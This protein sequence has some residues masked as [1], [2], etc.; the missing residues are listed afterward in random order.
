LAG[1]GWTW[2]VLDETGLAE[3]KTAATDKNAASKTAETIF[4]ILI[5]LNRM[6]C[7]NNLK[8]R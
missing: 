1:D 8:D 6:F 3:A 5:L 7:F 2:A 4:F